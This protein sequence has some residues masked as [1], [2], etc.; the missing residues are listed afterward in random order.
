MTGRVGRPERSRL[1][2]LSDDPHEV[3]DRIAY[4]LGGRQ[5]AIT[6]LRA[7]LAALE[8]RTW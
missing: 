8:A 2:T 5:R 4:A 3:A 1:I 6:W 7:V